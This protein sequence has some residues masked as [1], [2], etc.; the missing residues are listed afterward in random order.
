[1]VTFDDDQTGPDPE[2]MLSLTRF[3]VNALVL[4]IPLESGHWFAFNLNQPHYY[5]AEDCVRNLRLNPRR[6]A[7]TLFPTVIF[8]HTLLDAT[9]GLLLSFQPLFFSHTLWDARKTH[10]VI[11]PS[12]YYYCGAQKPRSGSASS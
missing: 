2:P 6:V 10:F 1:M 7:F 5:L 4:F 11:R 3:G 8:L 9:P 12:F